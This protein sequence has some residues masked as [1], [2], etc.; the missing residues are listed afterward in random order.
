MTKL[1]RLQVPRGWAVL[2]NKLYD[3]DPIVDNDGSSI[4]NW[5]EGFIEDVIWIQ[6]TK[7]TENGLVI[8]KHNHFNVDV[9]WYPDSRIEGEYCATLSWCSPEEMIDVEKFRSKN[10]FEI[11]DK[12]ESWMNDLRENIELYKNKIPKQ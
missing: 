9:G 6:E 8:P 3:I 11:R 7:L 1:L 4:A 10:R 12:I 5:Y 2:D